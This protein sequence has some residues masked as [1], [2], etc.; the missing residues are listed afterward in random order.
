VAA[1]LHKFKSFKVKRKRWGKPSVRIA[2]PFFFAPVC[3]GTAAG[4]SAAPVLCGAVPPR[5]L[6]RAFR[7]RF[8]RRFPPFF[9][10][11]PP[12]TALFLSAR[13]ANLVRILQ[14][15]SKIKITRI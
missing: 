13:N 1:K 11:N 10:L 6:F 15:D 2:C 5:R 3:C 8:R 7:R 4:P 12:E 9:A 14:P